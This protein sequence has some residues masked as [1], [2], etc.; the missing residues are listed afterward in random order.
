MLEKAIKDLNRESRE[1]D[2]RRFKFSA[3]CYRPKSKGFEKGN[4]YSALFLVCFTIAKS[5]WHV[6]KI[7]NEKPSVNNTSI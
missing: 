4:K 5:Y 3:T 7:I 1:F 6:Y 2:D